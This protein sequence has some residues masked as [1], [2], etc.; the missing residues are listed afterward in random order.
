[1]KQIAEKSIG[2]K[3][4]WA[5]IPVGGIIMWG[6][7]I[8]NIPSNW[9]LCDGTNGTPDLQDRFIVGAGDSYSVGGT[10][11]AAT[12]DLEH[13]HK[14]GGVLCDDSSDGSH[15]H[16][17]SG[18][19]TGAPTST[20]DHA[21]KTGSASAGSGYNSS[22]SDRVPKQEHIHYMD[23]G[24]ENAHTHALQTTDTSS[25]ANHTHGFQTSDNQLSSIQSIMPKYYAL[26]YI[27][28]LS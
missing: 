1:L 18:N 17:N 8:G 4:S 22:G 7:V 20:H 28:R 3:N 14:E 26:A 25:P 15:T 13:D 9:Q 12:I 2:V 27:Q 11:G 10:G 24:T 16:T 23:T 6:G 5:F 21:V 19:S